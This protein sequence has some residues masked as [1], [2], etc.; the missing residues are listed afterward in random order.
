MNY[1]EDVACFEKPN[2]VSAMP[3]AP[4]P[5]MARSDPGRTPS[6]PGVAGRPCSSPIVV[7]NS[8]LRSSPPNAGIEGFSSGTLIRSVTVPSGSMRVTHQ[9][10]TEAVQ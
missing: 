9:P 10:V 1:A 5:S 2:G 4:V 3:V 8:V 6:R 7:T